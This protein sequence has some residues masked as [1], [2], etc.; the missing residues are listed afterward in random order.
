VLAGVDD[1]III[2]D[3]GTGGDTLKLLPLTDML[4]GRQPA[5]PAVEAGGAR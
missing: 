2:D 4:Q 3:K 1:K 5:R